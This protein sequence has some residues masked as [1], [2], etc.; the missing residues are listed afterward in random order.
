MIGSESFT[1]R[2]PYSYLFSTES[3]ESF[4]QPPSSGCYIRA[5][6]TGTGV[7]TITGTV[8]GSSDTE[9][10][11]TFDSEGVGF[12]AK[13]FTAISEIVVE[14]FVT[15]ILYPAS[16]SGERI[17]HNSY[18]E[19][20]IIA[21]CYDRYF[22]EFTGQYIEFAGIKNKS[23]KTLMYDGRFVLNL[24]DLITIFGNQYMVVDVSSQ[25]GYYSALLITSRTGS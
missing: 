9:T 11:S 1:V 19:F 16:E 2:R 25:H 13:L 24:D 15:L 5:E 3:G 17:K 12:G 23:T 22:S 14:G 20:V 8:N 6:G 10:I 18:S 4:V 21:D 7:V